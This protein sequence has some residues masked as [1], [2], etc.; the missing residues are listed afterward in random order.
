MR[1]YCVSV[2]FFRPI[3]KEPGTFE[4]VPQALASVGYKMI[5]YGLALT[6]QRK[7]ERPGSNESYD[8]AC[9]KECSVHEAVYRT[10]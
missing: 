7:D 8:P 4:I 3:V 9:A 1:F 2:S 5:L 6:S 10:C